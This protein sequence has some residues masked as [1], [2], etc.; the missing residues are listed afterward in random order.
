M[1][2]Q[3]PPLLDEVDFERLIRDILRRVYDDPGIE[4]F[5]RDG[6]KQFGIDGLSP[7]NSTITFQCKLKDTRYEPDNRI[8]AVLLKEIEE[9]LLQTDG[10]VQPLTRFIFATTFKNDTEL[11]KKAKSLSS[12]VLTVEY[13]GWETITEKIWEFADQLIPIYYPDIPVR[14]VQGFKQVSDHLIEKSRIND[15]NRLK[16]LALEYYRI[17]DRTNIVF[18]IVVNDL[19]VRNTKVLGEIYSRLER[20][21][22]NATLWLIGDGGSGKTTILQ[23]TAVELTLRGNSVFTL[24][25]ETHLEM[26]DVGSILSLIKFCSPS[27]QTVVCIDNPAADEVTLERILREIP[28]YAKNVHVILA[29]RGHR[30]YALKRSGVLTYLHGEDENEPIRVWNSR[31]QREEVYNK[32]FDLLEVR[33]ADLERLMQ[34]IRD[35]QIVY[36][37][38]TYSILLELKK[39]RKIEFDFDWDDYRKTVANLSMF[40]EGY[41]YIS[42]FYLFGVKTPFKTFSR[43]CSADGAQQRQFLERFRGEVNEPIIVD[44]WR[45]KSGRKVTH[46]RTKHEIVSEIFFQEHPENLDELLMQWCEQ[47]DFSDPVETQP[48]I[49]IFGLKK[50]YLEESAHINFEKLIDFLLEGYLKEQVAISPRLVGTLN[51][52]KFW[53]LL[54]REKVDDAISVLEQ[55]IESAPQDSHSRTELAK[56]YRSQGRLA[57]A[58]RILLE[59]LKYRPDDLNSRIELAKIYQRQGKLGDAE[60]VLLLLLQIKENSIHGL[61]EI[62]KVYRA[63]HRLHDA[64]VAL[65]RILDQKPFDINAKTELA[66]I[67]Q[68]HDR[69][70]EAESLLL[71][72]LRRRSRD[73]HTRT[74]LAKIYQRQGKLTDAEKLL[75]Q[76]LEIDDKQLH[77]RTELAKIY[78]RQGKLAEAEVVLNQ[79]LKLEPDNLQARTEL[80][81]IYQRQGKLAEAVQRLEEYIALDPKGLHPRTELAKIY[82]RQ[83]KLADAEKLL[84]QSLEIDDKQLHPRTELAK[85][86]QRQGK[87]TEAITTAEEVLALDPI[88]DFAMSELLGAWNRQGEKEKC[89]MRFFAFIEQVNY[90]FSRYSQAPV[91]RFFQCCRKFGMKNEAKLVYERF[92]SELD[93]RNLDLY[94]STL[95]D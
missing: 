56:A 61:T 95:L 76:S 15:Q 53:L 40:S 59:I 20:V 52:A 45:D 36:V 11:Q 42:F 58:E 24:D 18:P 64:E 30:Y 54:L 74:E 7:G 65:E 77:P 17:N 62:A 12:T 26:A 6:Q 47:T 31:R 49:S 41:K 91:F 25:L 89:A 67:Y 71:D 38:A 84:L 94:Q 75:L 81:K 16:E 90:R 68:A 48:L 79:L 86:Y 93:E 32:L 78:Q 39:Q 1:S 46:L 51:L 60:S 69:L 80:A 2:Y 83:G 88:N 13:W 44:E 21:S 57:D 92:Q 82:Q 9:E 85:I 22:P 35:E 37:N 19:D 72:V 3:L 34:I 27:K 10:L 4:R 87:F 8:R 29:E 55:F 14:P 33:D 43:V 63:Q 66:K 28:D 73:L 70:A 5:G 23:R 50:N